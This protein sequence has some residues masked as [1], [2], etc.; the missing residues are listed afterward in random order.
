M[1]LTAPATIFHRETNRAPPY[2]LADLTPETLRQIAAAKGYDAA[3]DHLDA[4]LRATPPH[5]DFIREIEAACGTLPASR[6]IALAVVPGAFYREYRQTGADGG[7]FVG[8]VRGLN[9]QTEIIPT[10]SVG[11]LQENGRIITQW[12]AQR[13]APADEALILVSFSKGSA[14]VKTALRDVQNHAAFAGVRAWLSVGGI[15]HGTP[16]IAW[17]QA[18]P[19]RYFLIRQYLRLRRI[20]PRVLEEMSHGPGTLL[21]SPTLLPAS[22]PL[23]HLV[24]LPKASDLS[25]SLARRAFN[26]ILPLGPND[27]GGLLLGDLHR[28]PGV[29]YPVRDTD[30]YMRN[31]SN[32]PELLR[33]IL[34]AAA[35]GPGA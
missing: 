20:A 34:R 13:C 9:V 18:R 10:K 1:T 6:K 27:A 29:I 35:N 25:M 3:V 17:L 8:M 19:L 11:T 14:D 24:T 21:D 5:A 4:A 23:I 12:L 28:F 32:L 7:R 2:A 16:L 15:L 26:R 31:N 30:H 22:L 33:R